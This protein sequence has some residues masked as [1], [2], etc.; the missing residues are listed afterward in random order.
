M[1]E[2]SRM[3]W[4]DPKDQVIR[5]G[6][7]VTLS[8]A[9]M[10]EGTS[11]L[12]LAGET[13]TF[14]Q[15]KNEPDEPQF[16]RRIDDALDAAEAGLEA[17]ALHFHGD[18][19]AF[20]IRACT[21]VKWKPVLSYLPLSG[22]TDEW[23][24]GIRVKARDIHVKEGGYL[25]IR[26]E[27]RYKKEGLSDQR[28][29]G[30]ADQTV[31]IDF[32]EGTYDWQDLTRSLTV[33]TE[34]TANVFVALEG[35]H[36]T[37]DIWFEEP[38]LVS[39]NG[40]NTVPSF[41]IFTEDRPQFNWLGQNLSRKE[42]PCF[43]VRLNGTTVWDGPVF[44]RSHRYSEWQIRLPQ[45]VLQAE[46][47]L[48]ITLTSSGREPLPYRLHSIQAVC[49]EG[50]YEPFQIVAVP[51]NVP[52]GEEFGILVRLRKP[53]KLTWSSD[54]VKLLSH[55]QRSAGLIVLRCRIDSPATH[56]PFTICGQTA[57]IRRAVVH[58]QDGVI[59]GTGDMIY[60]DPTPQNVEEFLSWY[61]ANGV[62]N[63]LTIRPTYRWSGCR[64][65]D[66]EAWQT[67]V[68]ILNG[69]H[70]HYAHM[71][72]GRELPG[73]NTN[74]KYELL[75][76]PYFLGRQLHERDG[77]QCYWGYKEFTNKPNEALYYDMMIRML[78]EFPEET[79]PFICPENIISIGKGSDFQDSRI[80]NSD[81][82]EH[83]GLY[84]NVYL[85]ADMKIM[86]DHFVEQLARTRY[87]ATR[88][89]GPSSLFKYFYQAGY[90]WTGAETMYGP[91]ELVCSAIRGASRAY[92]HPVTGAHHAV[93]W[94]TTPH[95]ILPRYRRYR[96]ALYVSYM[97]GIDEINTEEGL[98]HME[99]YYH[100][101]D[102]FSEA[103]LGHQKQQQDFYRY[104]SSHSRT[105][106]FHTPIAFLQGRYD[107][108]RVFG[109]NGVWGHPDLP[110]AEP[111]ESWDLINYYY[112]LSLQDAIYR[113]PCVEGPVG[114]HTGTPH[115]NID[116]VPVEA[117]SYA[118]YKLI[119]MV[120]YNAC[121][122]EDLDKLML[123]AEG[124]ATVLLGWPQLSVTT[125]RADVLALHHEYLT[126][127]FVSR[128]AGAPDF[129][130]QH[131]DG[132]PVQVGPGVE[133]A[134]VLETT[135]EG[136][137]L[138]YRV[139]AGQGSVVFIN[140]SCYAIDPAVKEAWTRT[141][142]YLT[143]EV[144]DQEPF[145]VDVDE[146]V[147]YT[148]YRQEDGSYHLYLLAV[149]WWDPVDTPHTAVLHLN[150]QAINIDMPW[151][152]M[153]KVVISGA[154]AAWCDSEDGEVLSV[155]DDMVVAQ[156]VDSETFHV[157]RDG[158][159]SLHHLDFHDAAVQTILL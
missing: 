66:P 80:N 109:R 86:A 83:L 54:L 13:V 44:E 6:Q 5:P 40:Y 30:R 130:L 32:A 63:L 144:L 21:K 85:P 106:T 123:A 22:Y 9:P 136:M 93:Q 153:R 65:I 104:I 100:A 27:V 68:R 95:D 115:G 142:D 87:G 141:V 103:A 48:T 74:P 43:L 33:P 57:E 24:C 61:I 23:T 77:A 78:E 148:V 138:I 76:S 8:L 73:A 46:N 20:P 79:N 12:L 26:F 62:G 94:S 88:H 122:P 41:Q 42:W 29:Y 121:A 31:T 129:T 133:D 28:G 56:V 70:I 131:K 150:G 45:G 37:G 155:S 11:Q 117:A 17:Y 92:G 25:R 81:G 139:A 10:P 72:D 91:M 52:V 50:A 102:R 116:I 75:D 154:S 108:W 152:T 4:S 127:P 118:P 89:T 18:D 105:G 132:H 39:S 15:W 98:W 125:N 38:K 71:I 97:Q 114:F 149:D 128:F 64:A 146:N 101:H 53:M 84:R 126:H 34:E 67:L 110:C 157:A 82:K 140:A 3:I 19:D 59:T 96:L 47:E 145:H 2:T 143:A 111:E 113:H 134:E 14:Y 90:S 112:P 60:V 51:E 58:E 158:E 124:G 55:R 7:T 107:G 35:L 135:D 99:E 147:Q 119:A 69:M 120:G 159:E 1:F 36:F 137:P 151:G 49:E 16:Y 156:G